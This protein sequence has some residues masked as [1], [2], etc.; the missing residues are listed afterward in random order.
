MKEIDFNSI[1]NQVLDFLRGVFSSIDVFIQ[2][3]PLIFSLIV[4]LFCFFLSLIAYLGLRKRPFRDAPILYAEIAKEIKEIRTLLDSTLTLDKESATRLSN[5]LD[6]VSELAS[7]IKNPKK[8]LKG[9]RGGLSKKEKVKK[10]LK[11]KKDLK[12]VEDAKDGISF[13]D[14]KEI[15]KLGLQKAR[16]GL[17]GQVRDLIDGNNKIDSSLK[18]AIEKILISSDFGVSLTKEVLLAIDGYALKSDEIKEEEL[19]GLVS[20]F[21]ENELSKNHPASIVPKK[22]NS[23]PKIILVVGVNGVGKTT[24]IGKLGAKF[25]K[26]GAKVMFA[27]CDTFRA[28]ADEQLEVWAKKSNI[29]IVKGGA[30]V[31]PTTVA[32]EAVHRAVEED[33]D[34]LLIDT[35]GRLHNKV[36]LMNELEAVTK[37]ISREEPNAPHE[38]LLVVDASTGQNAINQAKEFNER[39]R[40]SGLILTKLDGT[41]KG[42]IVVSIKKNLGLAIRYVGVG[43]GE[44]DLREFDPVS[45][46]KALFSEDKDSYSISTFKGLE[47]KAKRGNRNRK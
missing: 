25:S 1:L 23:R 31:K 30:G 39:T 32:Y 29:E 15:L 24:T 13:G 8:Y 12:K 22:V 19:V 37:I 33:V 35:A 27:S 16:S 11:W 43:E 20:K 5:S 10:R 7:V 40:L 47:R 36:N 46:T 28:A 17:F 45:F 2:N 18:Q 9:S 21:V 34:V 44:E 38:V 3:D 41:Y 4:L 6:R 42:G 26:E 14:E